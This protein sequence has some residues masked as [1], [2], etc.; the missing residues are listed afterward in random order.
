MTS[1]RSISRLLLVLLTV[2]IFR[3]TAHA[4]TLKFAWPDDA[5]AKV[6][7]R[8]QGRRTTQNNTRNWDMTSDFT[9]SWAAGQNVSS[10]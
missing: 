2:V 3:S 10:T 5:S 7:A 9:M 1:H 4:Q 8:S 6:Q